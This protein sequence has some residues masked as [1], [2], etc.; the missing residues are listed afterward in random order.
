MCVSTSNNEK[1]WFE[2]CLSRYY[3]GSTHRRELRVKLPF[4]SLQ[5]HLVADDEKRCENSLTVDCVLQVRILHVC[6]WEILFDLFCIF[7]LNHTLYS[8][9]PDT[10]SAALYNQCTQISSGNRGIVRS[11]SIT[12]QKTPKFIEFS[13]FHLLEG[14]LFFNGLIP[15]KTEDTFSSPR[16]R[17]LTSLSV[18]I[19]N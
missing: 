11:K 19:I 2:T 13:I 4:W 14:K 9:S 12:N 16:W 1:Y 6:V 3:S 15:R 17:Q 8:E 18:F 10:K 7:I 5:R